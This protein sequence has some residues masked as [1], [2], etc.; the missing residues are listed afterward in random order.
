MYY[1]FIW[2]LSF[3][4]KNNE[5]LKMGLVSL[6]MRIVLHVFYIIPKSNSN[7][8]SNIIA[9]SKVNV[10]QKLFVDKFELKE[11]IEIAYKFHL[12]IYI[13]AFTLYDSYIK[14]VSISIKPSF[15]E[16]KKICKNDSCMFC[17]HNLLHNCTKHCI[18]AKAT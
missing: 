7:W 18:H 16:I 6:L 2:K 3:Y 15:E 5:I 9:S 14:M 8:H 4:K 11:W 12:W 10:E 17:I 1:L 13:R